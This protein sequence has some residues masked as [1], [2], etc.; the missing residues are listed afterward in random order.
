MAMLA[1][2]STP[3]FEMMNAEHPENGQEDG[4]P[5]PECG[6]TSKAVA[7]GRI[8]LDLRW[9]SSSKGRW[10]RGRHRL[11]HRLVV[12]PLSQE[13]KERRLNVQSGPRE[14]HKKFERSRP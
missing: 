3:Y 5:K 2:E 8:S 11:G 9:G 14:D 12:L 1:V 7:S 6:D 4:I 10:L 13:G